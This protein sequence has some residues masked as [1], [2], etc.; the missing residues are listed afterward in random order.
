MT[1]IEAT[2][3]LGRMP[4]SEQLVIDGRPNPLLRVVRASADQMIT[5][6]A[7]FGL[8]P[9]TRSL[10]S[11]IPPDTTKNKFAG[12][13]ADAAVEIVIPIAAVAFGLM[14]LGIVFYFAAANAV[15]L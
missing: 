10:L 4:E 2:E 5:I 9:A 7:Q 1:S 6:G 13:L 11:V 14:A 15:Q 8:S 3:V 12:L